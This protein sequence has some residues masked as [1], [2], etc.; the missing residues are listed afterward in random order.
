MSPLFDA[1]TEA[2]EEATI[3][4]KPALFTCGRRIDR[5]TIPCGYYAYDVRHDDDCQ[6]YAVQLGKFVLVFHW[7]T[8]ITRDE[9]ML[10]RG[11]LGID[12]TDLNYATGDCRSM[13]DFIEKYPPIA[14]APKGLER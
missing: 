8:L 1:M 10:T 11:Y 14:K 5:N 6:G 3:L 9:I 7:G 13:K 12:P 4:G 2:F